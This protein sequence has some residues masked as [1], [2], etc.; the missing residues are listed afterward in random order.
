MIKKNANKL[1]K[2]NPLYNILIYSKQKYHLIYHLNVK[3]IKQSPRAKHEM[4]IF[5]TSKPT[6]RRSV[7]ILLCVV[8]LAHLLI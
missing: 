7:L 5:S 8:D 3:Q 1:Y 2:V 6:L 4:L